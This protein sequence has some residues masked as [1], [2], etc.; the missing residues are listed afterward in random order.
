[1]QAAQRSWLYEPD[2]MFEAMATK[3][4][5]V[6]ASHM[7]LSGIGEFDGKAYDGNPR[8]GQKDNAFP[9]TLTY[10]HTLS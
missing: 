6:D 10:A 7:S 8:R 4:E 1:M 3:R 9:E 2:P 5:P